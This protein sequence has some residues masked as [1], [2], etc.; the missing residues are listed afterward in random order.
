[1]TKSYLNNIEYFLGSIKENNHIF[2]QSIGK[3]KKKAKKI[4]DKVGVSIRNISGKN[5]FSNDLALQSA[6]KIMKK[7]NKKKIDYVINCTQTPEYLIPTNACILQKK[8]KLEKNIGALDINLGCSGFIYLLSLAKGLVSSNVSKNVLLITSDTYSKLIDNRD[9][10]TKLI[11]S[12]AASSSL[13]SKDRTKNSLEILN[14]EFGTDGSGYKDFIC[15]NFGSKGLKNK[16]N[17]IPKIEMNGSKIFEFTLNTI[18]IFV[19]NF[20]KKNKLKKNN[21]KYFIFHQAS[22]LVLDNLQKKLNLNEKNMINDLKS[23]GNTVSSSIPI[24]LKKKFKI[25]K[26]NDLVLLC[27]FGVGL[28]WGA[29]LLRK[30]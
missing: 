24:I 21:I 9:L 7:I 12:D 23:I 13:V 22:Q 17:K 6:S 5:I 15:E 4:L 18:P 27:G 19:L 16:A 28:S 3:D 8:L 26:K 10:G 14:F 30:T 11:F 25:L 29:C 2:L 1:M 20:L